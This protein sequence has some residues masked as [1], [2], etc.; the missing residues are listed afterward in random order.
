MNYLSQAHMTTVTIIVA[1]TALAACSTTTDDNS[2]RLGHPSWC[3]AGK[4]SLGKPEKIDL[5]LGS[6][7]EPEVNID[8]L[9]VGPRGWIFGATEENGYMFII[10]PISRETVVWNAGRL[11]PTTDRPFEGDITDFAVWEESGRLII[12]AAHAHPAEIYRYDVPIPST[13]LPKVRPDNGAVVFH[14]DRWARVGSVTKGHSSTGREILLAGSITRGELIRSNDGGFSWV[15]VDFVST[16]KEFNEAGETPHFPN[17]YSSLHKIYFINGTWFIFTRGF[18]PLA[19]EKGQRTRKHFVNGVLYSTDGA[20][21]WQLGRVEENGK[22]PLAFRKSIDRERKAKRLPAAL[23]G[24]VGEA[25]DDLAEVGSQLILTT[26]MDT[27]SEP[28]YGGRLLQSLDRGAT[29]NE[30]Y[31]FPDFRDITLQPISGDTLAVGSVTKVKGNRPSSGS[32]SGRIFLSN[33]GGRPFQRCP[34]VISST[35][36]SKHRPGPYWVAGIHAMA[37]SRDTLAIGTVNEG[38]AAELII[39]PILIAEDDYR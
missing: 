26:A 24:L 16:T 9:K 6:P 33:N 4:I 8:E 14:S 30:I 10:N 35:E 32:A 11:Q 5:Q 21:S 25:A 3:E 20:E 31:H 28:S 22:I 37:F 23:Y 34:V 12:V 29:W 18:A 17:K 7:E 38:E 39:M 15:P 36:P 1:I 13:G 19:S 27:I 2:L